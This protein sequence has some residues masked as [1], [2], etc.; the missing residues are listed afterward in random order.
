[1][2][3]SDSFQKILVVREKEKKQRQKEYNKAI[4]SFEEVATQ[5]YT[6]L[7]KKEDVE[8]S[9]KQFL[10]SPGPITTLSTHYSF[11]ERIKTKITQLE[12]KV[13]NARK[14]MENE[15]SKLTEAH[16]EVKKFEK[17]IEQ[18]HLKQLQKEK[19]EETKLMDELSVIQFSYSED[20]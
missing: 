9:Y 16:I 17:L 2:T 12:E 4:D 14:Y 18:K 13:K 15:Q 20:R 7:K 10:E 19:N 3:Q 6:L 11:L 8:S 5:L 1:M